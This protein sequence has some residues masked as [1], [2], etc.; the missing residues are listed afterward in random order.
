MYKLITNKKCINCSAFPEVSRNVM[1][2]LDSDTKTQKSVN[3]LSAIFFKMIRF[4]CVI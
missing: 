2:K 4:L 3:I 1:K